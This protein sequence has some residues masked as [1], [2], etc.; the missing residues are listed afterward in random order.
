MNG[1][2]VVCI[3]IYNLCRKKRIIGVF[4][5]LMKIRL[6]F[7]FLSLFFVFEVLYYF[8]L[9]RKFL[10]DIVFVFRFMN[11]FIIYYKLRY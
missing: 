7:K 10:N 3:V 11:F 9:R 4:D 8:S 5:F 2:Y 6:S 1:I